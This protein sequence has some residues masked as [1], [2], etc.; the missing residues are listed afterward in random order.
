MKRNE[1]SPSIGTAVQIGSETLFRLL[2]NRC[3][4]W[5]EYALAELA[6]RLGGEREARTFL[7]VMCRLDEKKT[8]LEIKEMLKEFL[9]ASVPGNYPARGNWSACRLWEELSE[10]NVLKDNRPSIAHGSTH[11]A[12]FVS[13][14]IGLYGSTSPAQS[15]SLHRG[16]SR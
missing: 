9:G 1:C 8:G 6:P 4:S 5:S 10:W 13:V 16:V 14:C 3:S 15:F 7:E 12:W 2:R 11:L